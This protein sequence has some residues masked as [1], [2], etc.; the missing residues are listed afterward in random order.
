MRNIGLHLRLENSLTAVAQKALAL[1]IPLF[2]CFLVQ[3]GSGLLITLDDADVASYLKIRREHFGDVYMHGSYWINLAG[4]KYTK[5]FALDRELALAKKLEFTHIVLHPGSAKGAKTRRE[6]IEAMAR[7]INTTMRKE[8][9][10]KL[11]IENAA[12]GSMSI[13]GDMQDF[14]ALV[15]MLEHPE[16]I[17]FCLD[18]AHAHSFGYNLI[19]PVARETFIELVDATMGL[20]RIALLHVNDT[21]EKCGSCQDRH[22]VIGNGVLGFDVL[23][24]FAMHE[25]LNQIPMIM[26]LPVMEQIQEQQ[27]INTVK[28]WHS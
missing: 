27:I 3:Q 2:Q 26:E 8:Q 12:Y 14:G 21:K 7:I 22:E 4:V 5:H 6:G 11:V 25:K 28:Q 17:V 15:T 9:D 10:I 13:G 18:T 23:K 24:S 1:G 20:E 19:D 16:K